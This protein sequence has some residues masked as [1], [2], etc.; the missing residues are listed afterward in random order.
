MDHRGHLEAEIEPE[1]KLR[2]QPES[3]RT[4]AQRAI[5]ERDERLLSLCHALQTPL[6]VVLMRSELLLTRPADPSAVEHGLHSIRGAARMQAAIIDNVVEWSRMLE[7][8]PELTPVSVDL[9]SCVHDVLNRFAYQVEEHKIT[10][11]SRIGPGDWTVRGDPSRLTLAIH[12]LVGNAVQFTPSRGT[13]DVSLERGRTTA[14]V[15]I[16]DTGAGFSPA[17]GEL[18][19]NPVAIGDGDPPHRS[20][21]LRLGL[22]VVRWIARIHGGTISA[23][24]AGPSQGSSFVFTI[25]ASPRDEGTAL[26]SSNRSDELTAP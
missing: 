25:P 1:R 5:R 12:N 19:F 4:E 11:R 17:D 2:A 20:R 24:S 18:L 3:E 10:A 21:S 22:K 7:G 16:S 26:T 9:A 15:R 14:S 8:A 13:I 23:S 6:A